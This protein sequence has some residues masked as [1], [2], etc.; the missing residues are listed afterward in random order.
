[1]TERKANGLRR[2]PFIILTDGKRQ[3]KR[4]IARRLLVGYTPLEAFA[5][6]AFLFDVYSVGRNCR[7]TINPISVL[8]LLNAQ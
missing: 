7:R 3:I 6:Y 4:R 5:L 1:M 8:G 2:S